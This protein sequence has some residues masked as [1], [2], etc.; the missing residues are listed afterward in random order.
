[1]KYHEIYWTVKTGI[2]NRII[3]YGVFRD[4]TTQECYETLK[5]FGY[6][7][8]KWYEFWKPKIKLTK[9]NE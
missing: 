6:T 3:S 5:Y 2:S 9:H 4:R 8:P 7:E 1:M